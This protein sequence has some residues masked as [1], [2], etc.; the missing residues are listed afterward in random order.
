MEECLPRWSLTS[1]ASGLVVARGERAGG[2]EEICYSQPSSPRLPT[3]LT[4][5]RGP[6]TGE[7]LPQWSLT[8][9]ASG[10]C[11]GQRG[12]SWRA[13]GDMLQ[14]GDFV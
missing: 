9:V 11:G 14:R 7:C 3:G 1:V 5:P 8:S 10:L 4:T 12:K 13:G 6:P 2:L